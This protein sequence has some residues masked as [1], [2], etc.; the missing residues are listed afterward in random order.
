MNNTHSD[1]PYPRELRFIKILLWIGLVV[2]AIY[3][4]IGVLGIFTGTTLWFLDGDIAAAPVFLNLLGYGLLGTLFGIWV[5]RLISSRESDTPSRIVSLIWW[6]SI[7][8]VGLSVL[9]NIIMG[10]ILDP[11]LFVIRQSGLILFFYLYL[12]SFFRFSTPIKEHYGSSAE[13]SSFAIVNFVGRKL[14]NILER[15]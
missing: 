11:N 4:T 7:L 1:R 9:R 15:T 12:A 14:V 13:D 5:I 8:Q 3:L 10:S 6:F 2:A